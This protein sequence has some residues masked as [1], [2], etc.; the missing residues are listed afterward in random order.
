MGRKKTYITKINQKD[1]RFFSVIKNSNHLNSR[2]SLSI[3]SKNRL[4][5]YVKQGLLNKLHYIDNEKTEI[6]YELTKFGRDWT[7]KE[8]P[9][10]GN[11]FYISSTAHQHNVRLAD[12]IITHSKVNTSWLNERDLRQ[13]LFQAIE[14]NP[15]KLQL[16]EQYDKGNLSVPDGGYIDENG[17]IKCVEIINGNYSQQ[18]INAKIRYSEITNI[19]LTIIK[20]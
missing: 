3:V 2:Q 11:N 16:L 13:M 14:Q 20:I 15:H 10:L 1:E 6:I 18:Q 17:A 5:S 7:R 8:F 9:N 4:A 19:S 12:E